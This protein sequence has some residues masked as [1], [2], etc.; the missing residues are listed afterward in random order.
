MM[1]GT[2]DDPNAAQGGPGDTQGVPNA[3]DSGVAH[4]LP[5]S[6]QEGT[7]APA[8]GDVQG[9]LAELHEA[10]TQL[11]A[12][13]QELATTR[14]GRCTARNASGNPCKRFAMRGARVCWFHG[15][16]SPQSQRKAAEMMLRGRDVAIDQ[17]LNMIDDEHDHPPCE[18]CGCSPAKR[19]PTLLRAAMTVLDRTGLVPGVKLEVDAP[20]DG[21]REIR[22]VIV[23]ARPDANDRAEARDAFIAA[24]RP[25]PD[26]LATATD[27]PTDEPTAPALPAGRDNSV[28]WGDPT[29]ADAE[30]KK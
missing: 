25:V 8:G 24:G 18:H 1:S 16:A 4:C 20:V 21:I 28:V 22:R 6:P 19:D 10:R 17:L 27:E 3:P 23:Y 5:E 14:R 11:E 9:A 2:D 7:Q 12:A 13:N 15:G 29:S 30:G 26:W